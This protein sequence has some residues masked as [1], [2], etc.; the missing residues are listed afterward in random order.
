M[1]LPA[2]YLLGIITTFAVML[3]SGMGQPA[4]LY[5]VPFTLVT[6]AVVAFY[7]K[8]MRQFWTG[9]AYEVRASKRFP[10]RAAL[11]LLPRLWILQSCLN[12]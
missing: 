5:L 4:L 1:S 2:A 6:A 11:V 9:T 3:L 10:R 12:G 7:R 8:E